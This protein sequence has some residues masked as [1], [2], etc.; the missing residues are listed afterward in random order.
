MNTVT[1]TLLLAGL[2]DN[3]NDAVWSDFFARYQP[4]LLA[5]ARKLGM[6]DEDA[7]NAAQEALMAFVSAYREGA[8]DR[9]KGR[10]RTWLYGIASH[11]VR[12]MQ[13][14]RRGREL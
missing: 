10:L 14:K 13:R 2:K 11:K 6:S 8:Y 7:K 3:K 4:M 12:D 5:F 1:N 9:K